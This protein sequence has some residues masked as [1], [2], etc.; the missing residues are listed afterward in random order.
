MPLPQGS[1]F[2]TWTYCR[3]SLKRLASIGGEIDAVVLERDKPIRWLK[4]KET[5]RTEDGTKW[6]KLYLFSRDN[7]PAIYTFAFCTPALKSAHDVR[8][9]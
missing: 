4:R 3:D 5:C 8:H 6:P 9:V 2:P 7:Y 1:L